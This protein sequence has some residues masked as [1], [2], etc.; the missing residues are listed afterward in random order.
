MCSSDLHHDLLLAAQA[1]VPDEA[2]V[3][4]T[5]RCSGDPLSLVPDAAVDIERIAPHRGLYLRLGA[6]RELDGERGRVEPVH[7]GWHRCAGALLWM[8]R[9]GGEPIAFLMQDRR[10]RRVRP[11]FQVNAS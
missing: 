11:P 8:A 3:V 7:F 2:R 10:M 4:H 6:S 9:D 1:Q 5:W